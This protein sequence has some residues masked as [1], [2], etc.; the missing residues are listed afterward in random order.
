[1]RG[2]VIAPWGSRRETLVEHV[3]ELL[4]LM[5]RFL[6]HP[7]RGLGLWEHLLATEL[8][9]VRSTQ[10]GLAWW[11]LSETREKNHHI[12]I[13]IIFS[14]VC[15]LHSLAWFYIFILVL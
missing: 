1:M 4:S 8:P 15:I 9:S 10:R 12:N 2:I 14:V 3:I 6:R 11:Q 13:V 5:G 7:T